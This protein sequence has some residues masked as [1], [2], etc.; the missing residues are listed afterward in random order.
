[1]SM[2]KQFNRRIFKESQGREPSITKKETRNKFPNLGVDLPK[3]RGLSPLIRIK[4]LSCRRMS[5]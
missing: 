5:S 1:M 3:S 2:M 4:D